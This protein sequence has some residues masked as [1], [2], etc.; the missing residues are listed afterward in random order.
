MSYQSVC[1]IQCRLSWC[2]MEGIAPSEVH[3]W[4]EAQKGLREEKRR[5]KDEQR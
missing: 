1:P 4:M 3:C 5:Q 2:R